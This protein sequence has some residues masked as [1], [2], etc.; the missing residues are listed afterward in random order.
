MRHQK[1]NSQTKVKGQSSVKTK[2]N[3]GNK[4]A[5]AHLSAQTQQ[6]SPSSSKLSGIL[7]REHTNSVVAPFNARSSVPKLPSC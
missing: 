2:K 3:G 1:K 4:A 6:T 5:A 7:G